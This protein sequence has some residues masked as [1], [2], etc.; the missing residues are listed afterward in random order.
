MLLMSL[1]QKYPLLRHYDRCAQ[2]LLADMEAMTGQTGGR[3]A[4]GFIATGMA[5]TAFTDTRQQ[6][7]AAQLRFGHSV[8]IGTS[9][10]GMF[11]VTEA[12]QG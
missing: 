3:Q 6:H 9:R 4:R 1:V 5:L 10:G 8:A 12:G 2:R 7:I 11:G